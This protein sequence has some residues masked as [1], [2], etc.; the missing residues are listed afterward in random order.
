MFLLDAD[1]KRVTLAQAP[2]VAVNEGVAES[3]AELEVKDESDATISNVTEP[4]AAAT[5]TNGQIENAQDL[6]KIPANGETATGAATDFDIPDMSTS[7]E[8]VEVP[9]DAVTDTEP[10]VAVTAS[11]PAPANAAAQNSWADD[12]PDSPTEVSPPVSHIP[13]VL[14]VCKALLTYQCHIDN[15]CCASQQ[16]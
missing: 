1:I 10:G 13:T 12:Q 5:S 14:L 15:R 8:W 6:P 16:G 11:I 2:Q 9:R 4:E 7:Q 3:V